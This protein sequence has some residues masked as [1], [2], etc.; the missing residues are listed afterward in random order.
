MFQLCRLQAST[1]WYLLFTYV[2]EEEGFEVPVKGQALIGSNGVF[3]KMLLW[4]QNICHVLPALVQEHPTQVMVIHP[5]VGCLDM[6]SANE[7]L[8]T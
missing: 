8:Q 4:P 7:E 1:I 5:E 6:F 2:I 3:L